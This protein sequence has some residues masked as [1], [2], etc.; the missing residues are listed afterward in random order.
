MHRIIGLQKVKPF[1]DKGRYFVIARF[2]KH[3]I[4]YAIL[5]SIGTAISMWWLRPVTWLSLAIPTLLSLGYIFP[6]LN[7]RRR[8]RDLDSIKI[9]MIALVWAW[10]SVF[11]PMLELEQA[12]SLSWLLLFVERFLFVFA[13]T[14]PFDI[15]DLLIDEHTSVKTIP[16]TIGVTKSKQLSMILLGAMLLIVVWNYQLGFYAWTTCLGLLLSI[17]TTLP[18][19]VYCDKAKHDYYFSGLLDGTLILQLV[20]VYLLR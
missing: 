12:L 2:R 15:R 19:L 3:I 11:L 1:Q 9:Y 8:L 18:L 20:F 16:N 17:L 4:F 6:I 7:G 10:I 5:G 13:I 14:I